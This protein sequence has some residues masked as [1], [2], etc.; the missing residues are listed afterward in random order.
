MEYR[1]LGPTGLKVSTLG[2][3]CMT[4]EDLSKEDTY[5]E[6]FKK[7][8]DSGINFFDT[9]ENYFNGNSEILL[10]R[11]LKR[12]GIPREELVIST[13]LFYSNMDFLNLPKWKP[14]TYGL[15]RKHIIEG[16]KNSLKR[17]Q[18][19]YVDI[20]FCHRYDHEVPLEEIC[21]AM[22][23]VIEQGWAFYW[24]TSEWP[25]EK[26]IEAYGICD[27]LGLMRPV[28]EQPQYNMLVRERFEVEFG[29]LFDK[30]HMGSTI[31]SPLAAG[32]LTGKYNEEIPQDSRAAKDP[33]GKAWTV[34]RH[35]GTE[36]QKKKL[37]ETLKKLKEIADGLG[38]S[39][40]QLAL[41]WTLKN[42]DV[43]TCM[44]GATKVSQLED[45]LKALEL[46]KK[47][48]CN[49][50]KKIE[51]ALGNRPSTGMNWKAWQPH[52]PRR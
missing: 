18:L 16:V 21:R 41:A 47:L 22:N 28:V 2:F 19:D 13:K 33:I 35:M 15:S 42:K 26:I 23:W 34:D 46:A 6:I 9:A 48:D 1:F 27:K 43:S 10:G 36:E 29:E 39:L 50:L 45:N 40:P 4:F 44:L 12:S 11:C 25:A 52:V 24:G 17:L 3:G 8:Y 30:Y 31:W 5:F 38:G 14:N 49:I 37:L 32:I 51:D 20:L 7:C